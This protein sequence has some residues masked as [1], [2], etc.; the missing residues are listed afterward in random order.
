MEGLLAFQL[1]GLLL[2]LF[3]GK[4]LNTRVTNNCVAMETQAH[5]TTSGCALWPICSDHQY[6]GKKIPCVLKGG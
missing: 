5:Y 6:Q 2:Q 4:V 1:L 3:V